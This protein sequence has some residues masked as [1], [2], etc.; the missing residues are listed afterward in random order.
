MPKVILLLMVAASVIEISDASGQDLLQA[1]SIR[2]EWERGT[3]AEWDNGK[4]SLKQGSFGK[5]ATVTFDS[6]NIQKRTARIVGN[7]GASDVV[8]IP[9]ADGMTFLE[10]TA[11]GSVNVTTVF[12]EG[13]GPS[14]Q[15]VGVTSR[16]ISLSGPFPSQWHGPCRILQ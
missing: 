9:T 13:V 2:C 4:L 10:R 7:A 15:L 1:R 16:H 6:I 12:A 5:D 14:K 8:V 3:Q 11:L